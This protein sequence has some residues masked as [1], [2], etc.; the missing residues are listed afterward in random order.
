MTLSIFP[1]TGYILPEALV[2]GLS[3]T[4]RLKTLSLRFASATTH[5]KPRSNPLAS[6]G[7][8]TT[9]TLLHLTFECLCNYIE[10]ILSRINAPSLKCAKIEYFDQLSF[11]ISQFS[12]FLCRVESQRSPDGAQA[13][14]S[15]PDTFVCPPWLGV[16]SGGLSDTPK[17]FSLVLTYQSRL[18]LLQMIQIR[19]QMSPLPLRR[20][21]S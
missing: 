15:L 11:N 19:Q 12:Q 10:D 5:L 3:A 13:I 17:W 21:D 6:S 2:G 9:S 18:E 4:P 1:S 8:I 16:L 14:L 7:R 20:A